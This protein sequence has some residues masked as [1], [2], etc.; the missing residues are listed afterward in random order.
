MTTAGAG[1][2]VTDA[3]DDAGWIADDRPSA[4]AIITSIPDATSGYFKI[5]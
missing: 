3:A 2:Y 5:N 1:G 4:S